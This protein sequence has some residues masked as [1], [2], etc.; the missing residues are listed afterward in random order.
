[1]FGQNL[2]SNLGLG[3]SKLGFWGKKWVFP[4]SNLS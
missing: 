4:D 2:G 3:D 1:M